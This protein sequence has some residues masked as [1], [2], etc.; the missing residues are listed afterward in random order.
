MS[1]PTSGLVIERRV[2]GVLLVD[3]RGWL[4]LQLRGREAAI[5]PGQ[6]GMPGGGIEPGEQPEQAARR[7]LFEETG[8]RVAGPLALF[9]EGLRPA[10][11]GSGALAEWHVYCARTS[12]SQADVVLG[13]GDAME[14]TA[15][16]RV[17]SLDLSVSERF[18]LPRFLASAEYRRLAGAQ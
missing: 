2:A 16:D 12:A 6:W 11:S 1:D 8:L 14:F 3:A 5:S 13:E 18:F 15:P 7:E 17:P 10:S 9:W 4:L